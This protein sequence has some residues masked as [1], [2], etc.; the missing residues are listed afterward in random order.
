MIVPMAED[1]TRLWGNL[2][3]TEN[4]DAEMEIKKEAIEGMVS[5][6][7]SCLVGKLI[8]DQFVSKEAIEATLIRWWKSSRRITFKVL[9]ENMFLI[10]FEHYWDKSWVL[11]WRP[12]T[13]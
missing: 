11:E 8:L 6:G 13:F 1:L 10:D 2:S 4:E 9:G 7:K 12:W 3:L 5:R